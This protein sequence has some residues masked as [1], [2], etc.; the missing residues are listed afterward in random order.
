MFYGLN[1]PLCNLGL[2]GPFVVSSCGRRLW[3]LP[4]L[5]AS[6]FPL[7]GQVVPLGEV[8]LGGG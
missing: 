3:G 7:G 1:L 4:F 5:W 6:S 8:L 2:G